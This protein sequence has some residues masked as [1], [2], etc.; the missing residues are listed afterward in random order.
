MKIPYKVNNNQHGAAE[1]Q[2]INQGIR[3]IEKQLQTTKPKLFLSRHI[4]SVRTACLKDTRPP[5]CAVDK[6]TLTKDSDCFF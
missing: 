4:R 2:K 5:D 3:V 6:E 1:K